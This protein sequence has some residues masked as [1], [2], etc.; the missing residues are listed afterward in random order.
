MLYLRTELCRIAAQEMQK[1]PR[2]ADKAAPAAAPHWRQLALA[3]GL[4]LALGGC[5]TPRPDPGVACNLHAQ[6]SAPEKSVRSLPALDRAPSARALTLREQIARTFPQRQKAKRAL[7]RL[8]PQPAPLPPGVSPPP[9]PPTG[10]TFA[11]LALSAGGQFGAYGSGFLKGWGNRF[12]I[13][14]NRGDIDMVTG[15]STGAMMATYAYLGS[16]DDPAVREKYD[17]MLKAQYTTLHNEDVFRER[18]KIEL[19]WANS[20]YDTAPLRARIE[21]L[22]TEDLVAAVATEY[23]RSRRLLYVG[24][25]NADTGEFEYF[26]LIAIARD[27][28]H[29]RRACYSAAI[30]ASAAIPVAFTPVFI[31]GSMYVDGGARQHAFFLA[32]AAA[33]LPGA[34]KSL[35]GVIHGDLA[36]AAKK[37]QNGLIAIAS[38]TSSIA[39][40]QLLLDSA[41]Y[42]DAEAKRLGY[43]SRWTAAVNTACR[44][45]TADDMFDPELGTCLWE[46][47]FARARDEA[48]P[49]KD[50][51][52]LVAP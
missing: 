43:R 36:V 24:A 3:L 6:P 46:A 19:L 4:L 10:P 49:W 26:D 45:T 18:S 9:P 23:E 22:I 20:I 21:A 25:V 34:S 29:D 5:A 38:R 7:P 1:S 11:V 37:T 14:P 13:Q 12:D 33:A 48:N 28:T 44:T 40:D 41:Y 42:V 27:L 32:N 52:D 15:V 30:L 8:E 16:S 51:G 47:G 17:A 50:L 2:L 39:T 31:N 35:F